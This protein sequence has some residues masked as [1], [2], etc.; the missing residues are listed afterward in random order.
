M[1]IVIS[2]LG[3][4]GASLAMAIKRHF[5]DY[6]LSGYDYPDIM[7][8]ALSMGVIDRQIQ[9]WPE[10]CTSADI[11]F[12]ATPLRTVRQ[13]LFDL[14]RI[15]NKDI[16]VSDLASTKNELTE[17]CRKIKFRGTYIGGHPM[18]GAEKSG[19]KSAN[20]LLYENAVYIFCGVNKSNEELFR[21]RLLPV[22]E[23]LKARIMLLDPAVHDRILAYIS[24]LPQLIAVDMVNM[25]GDKNNLSEP[26]FDLAA[27]GFRDITRI[28]SSSIDIWQD[29]LLSNHQNIT[30][31][32]QELI[33]VLQNNIARLNDLKD[34]FNHA[35]LFREQIPKTGKGFLTPLTDLLVY[36]ADEVGVIARVANALAEEKIDIRDIELLKIREKEGGVFRLSFASMAEAEQ[37]STVL[38]RLQFRA[39]IRE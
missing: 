5:P 11:I 19:I 34:E 27:G 15:M 31:A 21:S 29:I 20:P 35:N 6:T 17:Y 9:H 7:Q 18:T 39:Y 23:K 16:L 28:A 13:H 22:M 14:N 32:L 10:D 38:N 36:V 8:T 33:A 26:F 12:L 30:Q 37:A 4:M 25:V 1:Q 3:L 24:H 2:G